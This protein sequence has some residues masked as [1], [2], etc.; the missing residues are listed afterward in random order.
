L[1]VLGLAAA[2]P[3]PLLQQ[4]KKNEKA[5]KNEKSDKA[6]KGGGDDKVETYTIDN[7]HSI[8][9]FRV[10]HMGVS[11]FYGHFK[12]MSGAFALDKEDPG[13]NSVSIEVKAASVETHDAKRDQHLMSPDF[14]S[15]KEFP[16]I[17]FKSTEVEEAGDKKFKVTGDF[18]LHG[19]TKPITVEVEQV[20][21]ANVM[22]GPRA[23]FETTFTISRKDYGMAGMQ[24]GIG[25]EVRIT[26]SVEGFRK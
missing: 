23:G 13:N 1:L 18:T 21:A 12:E 5:D 4:G 17:S 16:T 24:D 9:L 6:V 10:K 20:G 14:F 26:V 19:K 11:N 8:A 15:A 2:A 7:T 22:G 3:S 25:D